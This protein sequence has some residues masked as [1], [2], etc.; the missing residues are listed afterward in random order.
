[1]EERPA[2]TKCQSRLR[3]K[4]HIMNI[5]LTDS[6]E[7]VTID[8]INDHEELY[9]KT[10]E[11]FK[12]KARKALWGKFARGHKLLVKVCKTSFE[13]QRAHYGKLTKSKSVQAPTEVTERQN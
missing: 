12:D 5:H 6:D 13:S 1:M 4:G 11:K 3:K 8:F 10:N 7:E 9:N 2:S